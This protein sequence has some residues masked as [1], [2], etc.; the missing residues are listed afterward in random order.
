MAPMVGIAI[1]KL[2]LEA[3]LLS[4]PNKSPADMVNPDLEV[5]GIK[6]NDWANPIIKASLKVMF[7]ICVLWDLLN[8]A[9]NKTNPK[10]IVVVAITVLV[11]R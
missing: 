4:S 9:R 6:A 5:P 10:K 8:V 1:K 2:N 7:S 11:R 3:V